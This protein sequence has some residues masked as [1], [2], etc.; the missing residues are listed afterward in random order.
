MRFKKHALFREFCSS[1][2]IAP[3]L[4]KCGSGELRP[5]T[6]AS[7]WAS[8][9]VLPTQDHPLAVKICCSR[10]AQFHDSSFPVVA[11]P[12]SFIP[13]KGE[14]CFLSFWLL[15]EWFFWI[16]SNSLFNTS[17]VSFLYFRWCV[18]HIAPSSLDPPRYCH[19]LCMGFFILSWIYLN[20]EGQGESFLFDLDF[21]FIYLQWVPFT[22]TLDQVLPERQTNVAGTPFNSI[23]GAVI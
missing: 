7:S 21:F 4:S 17:S 10:K 18:S 22:W 19:K 23:L 1:Y 5:P 20:L 3:S 13:T 9:Q 12:S 2:C 15:S 6:P 14:S 11:C 16:N 8:G